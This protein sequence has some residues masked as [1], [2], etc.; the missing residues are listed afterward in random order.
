MT[1]LLSSRKN[2]LTLI[3]R[4]TDPF[5]H[6]AAK[7]VVDFKPEHWNLVYTVTG[8]CLGHASFYWKS[9]QALF[10][11]LRGTQKE[12]EMIK[13]YFDYLSPCLNKMDIV[14]K[15]VILQNSKSLER[16]KY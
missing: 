10:D 2:S 1:I 6:S 4:V 11:M 12:M 8:R 3:G 15:L 14:N 13:V 16:L 9:G 7:G 5:I